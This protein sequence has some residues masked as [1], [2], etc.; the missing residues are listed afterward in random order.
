MASRAKKTS[1]LAE[2]TGRLTLSSVQLGHRA[3]LL[4]GS[5][6]LV[7]FRIGTATFVRDNDGVGNGPYELPGATVVL[8]VMAPEL[9]VADRSEVVD[10][11]LSLPRKAP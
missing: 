5:I 2:P 9:V 6:V 4:D 1:K 8:E 7:A 10:P 11:L 3:R